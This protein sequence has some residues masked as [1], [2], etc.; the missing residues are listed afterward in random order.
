M[1]LD[2]GAQC[3]HVNKCRQ[4]F[5]GRTVKHAEAL[6]DNELQGEP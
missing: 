5:E 3:L 2:A 6:I 1:A 4:V